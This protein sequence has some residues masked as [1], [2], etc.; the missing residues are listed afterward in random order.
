MWVLDQGSDKVDP[1]S[2]AVV[3]T[4]TGLAGPVHVLRHDGLAPEPGDQPAAG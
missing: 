2:R 4:V 1:N 3:S